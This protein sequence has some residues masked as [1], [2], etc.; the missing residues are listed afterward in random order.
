V[1]LGL[2]FPFTP[3]FVI[4]L[5]IFNDALFMRP[6]YNHYYYGNYYAPKYYKRGIYP[7]F[8][9]HAR[10]VAYDP[11]YAHQR[12]S[13][14]NDHEWENRLQTKFHERREHQGPQS[15]RSFDYRTGANKT[16]RPPGPAW[17][18]SVM[19]QDNA[20][21]AKPDTHRFRPLSN[22]ERKEFVQV[23]KKV[24]TN[25]MERQKRETQSAKA[26]A[27]FQKTGTQ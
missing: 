24:R 14:R 8:S 21:K 9:P 4:N 1:H 26:G 5:S 7:W 6:R 2:T 13:H 11:I 23:E 19:P 22:K 20:A 27:K 18:E 25:K 12:W 10:R 3:A 17:T 16:G 15:P